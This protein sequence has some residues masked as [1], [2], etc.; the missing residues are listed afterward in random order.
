MHDARPFRNSRLPSTAWLYCARSVQPS[1]ASAST[2]LHVEEEQKAYPGTAPPHLAPKKNLSDQNHLTRDDLRL[3]G[4]A[5][6]SHPGLSLQQGA[7]RR[8]V[9]AKPDG[10]KWDQPCGPSQRALEQTSQA[11][12]PSDLREHIHDA[13]VLPRAAGGRLGHEPRLGQI[14]GGSEKAGEAARNAAHENLLPRRELVLAHE[15]AHCAFELAVQAELEHSVRDIPEQG[16]RIAGIKR[17]GALRA[18]D[19]GDGGAQARVHISLQALLEQLAGDHDDGAAHE[20]HGGARELDGGRTG[21]VREEVGGEL[22]EGLEGGEFDGAG[23]DLGR[24]AD[25]KALV[26]RG[27]AA[28]RQ[29]GGEGGEG[30]AAL[31]PRRLHDG[32]HRVQR[33]HRGHRRFKISI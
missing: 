7:L 12:G 20:C 13:L 25:G 24:Q 15:G 4:L 14:Q 33:V 16:G 1:A 3:L 21:A 8:L 10:G 2:I 6:G 31:R 32:L 18:G 26:Q 19:S 30:R 11:L 29:H 22:G 9:N 28:R 17:G 27:Q 5:N 23:R